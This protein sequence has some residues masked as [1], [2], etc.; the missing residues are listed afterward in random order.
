M[1]IAV[2]GTGYIGLVTG[3]TFAEFGV[4]VTCIDVDETKIAMLKE[5]KIP[6][7]EPGL[8]EMVQ[9]NMKAGRLHFTTDIKEGV[10]RVP[11][12]EIMTFT[13]MIKKL[14]RECEDQKLPDAIRIGA[15]EGMQ[16]FTMSLKDLVQRELIDRATAFEVAPNPESLKMALKGIEVKDSGIL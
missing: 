7:Y 5:G 1:H 10:Q 4:E 11:T 12:V 16:D 9:R 8:E 15:N 14:I 13:P 6:I 2:I 3:T